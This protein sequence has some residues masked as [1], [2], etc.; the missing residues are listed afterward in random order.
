MMIAL[1][2]NFVESFCRLIHRK[3]SNTESLA[4]LYLF[5]LRSK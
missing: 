5:V 1:S 3:K 2:E 4:T